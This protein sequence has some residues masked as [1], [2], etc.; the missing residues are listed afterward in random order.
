ML[1]LAMTGLV[2][3]ELV[4]ERRRTE[5][6][7]RLHQESLSRLARLGS[8]GELAAAVAHELNQPLMAA[9]TYTRLVDD[10][11]SC[12]QYRRRGGRGD[13]QE[14]GGAGRARRRSGAAPA[15]AGPARPQQPRAV[16]SNASSRRHSSY[17]SPISTAFMSTHPAR[18]SP[19]I[20]RPS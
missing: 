2:A 9:G 15:G 20:C 8:M 4:T 1:V 11:M 12:G 10:A 16:A 14:G 5:S 13:R 7:L 6:Q 19:P 17:A 3:G 18:R